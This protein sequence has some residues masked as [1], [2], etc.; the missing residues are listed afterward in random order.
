M[1]V[2]PRSWRPYGAYLPIDSVSEG[3]IDKQQ[4]PHTSYLTFSSETTS[5][6][7]QI[8]TTP[9]QFAFCTYKPDRPLHPS[10]CVTA[11]PVDIL[12]TTHPK[13]R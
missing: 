7:S 4:Q 12:P 1:L 3:L 2:N 11:L 8:S 5:P 13:M 10:W 6:I 9:T